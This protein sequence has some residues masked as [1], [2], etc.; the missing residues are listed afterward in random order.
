MS[1]IDP[2]TNFLARSSIT[3]VRVTAGPAL[4]YT[5]AAREEADSAAGVDRIPERVGLRVRVTAPC[6]TISAVQVL[7][8][9]VV[10]VVLVWVS[11]ADLLHSWSANILLLI[12]LLLL[13]LFLLANQLLYEAWVGR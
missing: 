10:V 8:H 4:R 2:D 1:N 9:L 6:A 11:I 13:L 12:L 7:A 5:E 3:R